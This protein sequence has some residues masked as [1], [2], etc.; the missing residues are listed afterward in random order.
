VGVKNQVALTMAPGKC[1]VL[2][3]EAEKQQA[4]E[5]AGV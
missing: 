1:V 4:N 2:R 3:R 5:L